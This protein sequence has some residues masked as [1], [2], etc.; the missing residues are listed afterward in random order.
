MQQPT[1]PPKTRNRVRISN[2]VTTSPVL[3][4]QNEL[5]Q[6]VTTNKSSPT[7]HFNEALITRTSG[8]FSLQMFDESKERLEKLGVICSLCQG[9]LNQP[10]ESTVW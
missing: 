2:S 5:Q 9:V 3:S 6:S 1:V 4:A 10:M 7:P 8:G